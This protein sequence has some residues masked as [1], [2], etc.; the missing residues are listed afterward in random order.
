MHSD[1]QPKINKFLKNKKDNA[2]KKFSLI[3]REMSFV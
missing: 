1:E 2:T 3:L